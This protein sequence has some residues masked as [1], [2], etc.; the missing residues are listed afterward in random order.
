MP[1]AARTTR[2]RVDQ[3]DFGDGYTYRL[4]RGLNPAR[5]S[6]SIQV[7]FI[8]LAELDSYDTFLRTNAARGFW[9]TPPDSATDVF[10][11][12]DD[13]SASISDRNQNDIVGTLQATF[14][15]QFNPQPANPA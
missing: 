4:T 1:G 6:W 14:T 2:L 13:W 5:P 3:T 11:T 10:V 12:A 9:F 7:P 8:G 15:R